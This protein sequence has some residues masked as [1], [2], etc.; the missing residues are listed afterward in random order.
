MERNRR[1]IRRWSSPRPMVSSIRRGKELLA[2]VPVLVK[3]KKR[4]Q[5]QQS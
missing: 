4:P 5:K 2:L 1:P 3:R